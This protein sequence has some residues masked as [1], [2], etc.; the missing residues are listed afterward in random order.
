MPAEALG[1][2]ISAG[3]DGGNAAARIW[4]R[5]AYPAQGCSRYKV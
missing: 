5:Y 3:L 2:V 4:N 1:G